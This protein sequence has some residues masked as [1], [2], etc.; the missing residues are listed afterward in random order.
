MILIADLFLRL[1]PPKNVLTSMAKKFR[2][3]LA[4]KNQHGKRVPTLLKYEPLPPLPYLLINT[5]SVKL[6]KVSVSDMQNL[7]TVS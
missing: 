2:F 3:R 1:R 6:Q 4:F 5:K 7:K